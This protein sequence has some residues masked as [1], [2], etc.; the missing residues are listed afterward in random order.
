MAKGKG[1]M[2]EFKKSIS[3]KPIEEQIYIRDVESNDYTE[4]YKSLTKDFYLK[5]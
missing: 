4:Q 1:F 5:F 2:A 3:A